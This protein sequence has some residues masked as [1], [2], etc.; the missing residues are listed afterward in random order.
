[1]AIPPVTTRLCPAL[2]RMYSRSV[3]VTFETGAQKAIEL[4]GQHQ[5]IVISGSS[6][7]SFE[8]NCQIGKTSMVHTRLVPYFR[9]RGIDPSYTNLSHV[10]MGANLSMNIFSD[11]YIR[12]FGDFFRNAPIYIF[13]EVHYLLLWQ[14]L[15]QQEI[16]F[17]LKFWKKVQAFLAQKKQIIFIT[18]RHP[19]SLSNKDFLWDESFFCFL[20]APV[21]ELPVR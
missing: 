14:E 9:R 16:G 1:M 10:A 8:D 3:P 13:D 12:H 21:L 7:S 20:S 6:Q 4:L 15:S 18:A 5:V 11:K 2:V 17:R 19:L